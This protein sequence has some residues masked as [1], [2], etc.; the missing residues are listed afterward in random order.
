V[1]RSVE[2]T[3]ADFDVGREWVQLRD[4]LGGSAGAVAAFCGLVRDRAGDADIESLTL[5]HYP[6]MTE[7][8]ID[9]ILDQAAARWPLAAVR[10]IHRVGQLGPGDQIVLV[11]TASAHRAAA[12]AAC[13]FVMDYLKTDAVLWK[14]EVRDGRDRWIESTDEDRA[15]HA[16]WRTSD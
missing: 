6:G 14:R 11:L 15:R 12:F 7:S 3:T 10:V 16:G 1:L 8:S 2:V 13:E 9:K 4:A 5:E